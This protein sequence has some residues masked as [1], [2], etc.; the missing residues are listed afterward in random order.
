LKPLIPCIIGP[1]A[2]G[3]SAAALALA[4]QNGWE[5]ISA[6][7]RQVYRHLDIATA[8]PSLAERAIVPHHFIDIRNP[9][10]IYSAG[11]FAREARAK[12]SEI[13]AGGQTPLVVGGSG[14]YIR[15]LSEG[16]FEPAISNRRFQRE[17]KLRA[18]QVG[19]AAIH[20]ELARVDAAMAARLHPN[21]VHRI[22]RALEVYYSSGKP[23]S[24]FWQ[25]QPSQ[26]N[27]E[28][29][30]I[31]LTMPRQQL[32]ERIDRRVDAMK[33]QGLIDECRR[34][35]EMGYTAELNALQTVGYKE[36]F[37]F[38]SGQMDQR[39][40]VEQIKQHTRNYAKR[41]MTWFRKQSNIRWLEVRQEDSA[42]AVTK[43]IGVALGEAE[44]KTPYNA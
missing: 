22:A 4:K 31:G 23:L 29:L 36:V 35:L 17:L 15:A 1:T 26:V 8:K 28:F 3:K 6:D 2:V 33:E 34:L 25:N 30:F 14:L 38:L 10:E 13:L 19:G 21:D 39:Q 27:F 32:Y 20:A 40:M 24:E 11:E 7:S 18:K 43:L 37:A 16:F 5:I 42:E 41:Q 9:D 12:I 44:S